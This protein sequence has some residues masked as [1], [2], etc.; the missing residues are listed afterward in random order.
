MDQ[1]TAEHY[2]KIRLELRRGA[3]SLALLAALREPQYGYSL[4]KRLVE[5]GLDVDE[6]TLYPLLRRLE[7]QGLLHSQWREMQPRPRRYYHLNANG[8]KVLAELGRDWKALDMTLNTL[9]EPQS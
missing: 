6:G 9:L 8:K 4:R 3:I 2:D 5:A 1:S 7:G